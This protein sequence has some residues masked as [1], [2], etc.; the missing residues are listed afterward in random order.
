MHRGVE[1]KVDKQVVLKFSYFLNFAEVSRFKPRIKED[2]ALL[3]VSRGEHDWVASKSLWRHELVLNPYHF[4]KAFSNFAFLDRMGLGI[5]VLL[6]YLKQVLWFLNNF[7]VTANVVVQLYFR[8]VVEVVQLLG[9]NK[10]IFLRHV[11]ANKSGNS[12]GLK[13]CVCCDVQLNKSV[14]VVHDD[15]CGFG[16]KAPLL[17]VHFVDVQGAWLEVLFKQLSLAFSFFFGFE[18]LSLLQGHCWCRRIHRQRLRNQLQIR[19]LLFS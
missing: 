11:S 12:T 2:C 13:D 7:K 1:I 8:V 17:Q 15:G 14:L 16:D 6:V 4:I 5:D 19:I 9:S 10:Q 18:S 3:D